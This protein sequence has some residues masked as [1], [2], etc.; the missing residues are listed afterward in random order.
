M[1]IAKQII[2]S[3]CWSLDQ[4]K[5]TPRAVEHLGKVTNV[6]I[7]RHYIGCVVFLQNIVLS[8]GSTMFRDFGRKMQRDVKRIVDQ[9]LKL[10]EELSGGK[11][12]VTN[13]LI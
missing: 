13:H 4:S 7:S 8:G 2:P 5:E 3:N 1:P 11:L 6:D 10:S 12:K 9:R